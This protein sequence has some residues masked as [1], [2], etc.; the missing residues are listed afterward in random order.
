MSIVTDDDFARRMAALGPFEMAP[1]LAVALS[2]GRDS[3]ALALLADGWA[4]SRGGKVVAITVDH[5]LR[6]ESADEAVRVGRW[7]AARGIDHRIL[8]WSGQKPATGIQAAARRARYRLLEDWCRDAGALHLLLGHHRDDQVETFLLRAAAGSGEDGLAAMTA[9][10]ETAAVRLLRPLLDVPRTSL[11]ATLQ[12]AGQDWI[13]DPSNQDPAYARTRIRAQLANGPVDGLVETARRLGRAR[14]A[15]EAATARMLAETAHLHPAGFATLDIDQLRSAPDEPA[16]RALGA[17]VTAVGG[18][19]HPP[20]L[21][22][23]ERLHRRVTDGKSA[24]LARC[25]LAPASNGQIVVMR[26][27]RNLPAPMRLQPGQ[28]VSWDGRFIVED[29]A[30]RWLAPLGD[31]VPP[32]G[33]DLPVEVRRALPAIWRADRPVVLPVGCGFRRNSGTTGILFQFRPAIA[34]SGAGFYVA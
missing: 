6:P 24:T 1:M 17:V 7:M 22:R 16:I 5:G 10:R 30:E 11:G 29:V 2:G 4:R 15:I 33:S 25:R 28:R 12:Q 23:L 34:L 27:L 14:G 32:G 19:R 3:M 26:E 21:D 8:V 13:D 31:F 18:R 9:V 20:S